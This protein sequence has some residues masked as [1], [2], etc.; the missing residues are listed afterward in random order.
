MKTRLIQLLKEIKNDIIGKCGKYISIANK[1]HIA[2]IDEIIN[3]SNSLDYNDNFK[4]ILKLTDDIVR[5]NDINKQIKEIYESVHTEYLYENMRDLSDK[6][7]WY[8]NHYYRYF[9]DEI[10]RNT[11][12]R[13]HIINII[14]SLYKVFENNP[15]DDWEYVNSFMVQLSDDTKEKLSREDKNKDD[16]IVKSSLEK[17]KENNT[18][19]T[20]C[21]FTKDFLFSDDNKRYDIVKEAYTRMAEMIADVYCRGNVTDDIKKG[22]EMLGKMFASNMV[23][24]KPTLDTILENPMYHKDYTIK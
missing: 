5:L 24:P 23:F 1:G 2:I 12:D 4:F 14:K 17:L 19:L 10:L 13:K 15:F 11:P 3:S 16:D 9:I 6:D 18:M 8:H 22:C 21:I 7:M 20:D